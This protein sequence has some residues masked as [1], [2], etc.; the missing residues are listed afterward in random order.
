MNPIVEYVC[1]EKG[2][3]VKMPVR[4]NLGF[5][6]PPFCIS[7]SLLEIKTDNERCCQ[8]TIDLD[9]DMIQNLRLT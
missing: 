5:R 4:H 3:S 7:A 1:K 9:T 2:V 8:P 6:N